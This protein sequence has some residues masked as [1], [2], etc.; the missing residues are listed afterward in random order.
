M[1]LVSYKF[2]YTIRYSR[3]A[4]LL[5]K[6]PCF[7]GGKVLIEK[8]CYILLRPDFQ[9]E[10]LW[11]SIKMSISEKR[12]KGEWPLDTYD[13]YFNIYIS[14]RDDNILR[15]FW[16][17]SF[18]VLSTIAFSFRTC[19]FTKRTC[20]ATRERVNELLKGSALSFITFGYDTCCCFCYTR[21]STLRKIV[22]AVDL[23]Q[24]KG[25]TWNNHFPLILFAYKPGH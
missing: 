23:F 22:T 16:L 13:Y 9:I 17:F 7:E 21:I 5:D 14:L 12:E 24:I 1:I 3:E 11:H 20:S 25:S 10:G 8:I 15:S 4:S 19:A 18:L 2:W 6:F